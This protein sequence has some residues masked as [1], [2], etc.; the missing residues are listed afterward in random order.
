[1]M[2]AALAFDGGRLPKGPRIGFVT[3]SGGTVDLLYDYAEA[4]GAPMPDYSPETLKGLMPFMQEGIEP[5]NPLDLGI[6]GGLKQAAGVCE[7]VA[8]DP[9][10][11][12]IAWAAMLPSKA[13]AWD[14][15]EPL[16]AMVKGTDKPI[17]G[18]GRMS[19]Q[20]TPEAVEAQTQ[21]GFPFLQ[22]LEPTCA[23]STGCGSMPRA[24]ASS[25]PTPPPAPPSDL[26]PATLDAT[27]KKYGIALPQS[28]EVATAAEA[29]AAA[30][31][32]GFPVVLKIRSADILH[33][34]EAGGVALDLRSTRR[35]AARPP[36]RSPPRHAPPI[37]MRSIDG[38]LV[39][40][41]VSGIEAIVGARTDTL[42]GPMLL[43]GAGG[44]LV[45][46]AKDAALRLLPVTKA[47][48]TAMIDGLK[49]NKLLAGY[50]GRPAADRAA[51]EATVLA[52]AQFYLDHR[53]RIEDIEINPLM[54]RPHGKA[55]SPSTCA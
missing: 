55:P 35:R 53:A 45:E 5:K 31:A 18:F 43:V 29:A 49:L 3:T 16:Q 48:V 23:R 12:M 19:Y 38:F 14:G 41:M 28:R 34:T 25:R 47:D 51:L 4:E 13:G 11:D 7:V 22:G 1:M 54:V 37:R 17:V 9:N 39:Q 21:A 32:I 6:P 33:K 46:L 40:E 8:K 44:I 27:L 2:E 30:E 50:R 42:Y 36:T 20:M 52:L 26:S 15:V 24:P 10:I